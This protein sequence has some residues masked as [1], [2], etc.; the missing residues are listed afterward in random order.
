MDIVLRKILY[1]PHLPRT[2]H[3]HRFYM[4]EKFCKKETTKDK[5][6]NDGKVHRSV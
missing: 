6:E 3:N 5:I 4:I 1:L 2:H